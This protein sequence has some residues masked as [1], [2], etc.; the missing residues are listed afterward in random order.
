M[1][2]HICGNHRTVYSTLSPTIST[3]KT[4][5]P[6]LDSSAPW[7]FALDWM[8]SENVLRIGAVSTVV[9]SMMSPP[10]GRPFGCSTPLP[11]VL[12]SSTTSSCSS[13]L[14]TSTCTL[15]S[16]S[17]LNSDPHILQGLSS[18]FSP[19]RIYSSGQSWL[20]HRRFS[21]G[22]VHLIPHSVC[23]LSRA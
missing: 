9:F 18:F 19:H 10:S 5:N 8:A 11:A 12:G 16:S 13:A 22:Y 7:L 2:S 3:E 17:G 15:M 21:P 4:F 23:N 20:L 1:K 14:G 6:I